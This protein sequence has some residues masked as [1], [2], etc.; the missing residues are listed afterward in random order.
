MTQDLVSTI[1][2]A[3]LLTLGGTWLDDPDGLARR[4]AAFVNEDAPAQAAHV[5]HGP[6]GVRTVLFTD[7]VGHTEMMRR[8]GDVRGRDVLREHERIVR[9]EIAK[10]DGTEI[11]S[12]GDGF[13]ISFGSVA[14]A[15]ECAVSIQRAAARRNEGADEPILLRMG[16][17]AGE[18]IEDAGDLFG[19]SVILAARIGAQA[20]SGEI[21]VPETVRH[22]LAGKGFTFA[23]RGTFVP[24]GF[25]DEVRLFEVRWRD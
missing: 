7:L 22:L 11:K 5:A 15:M 8:L 6:S 2:D 10:H 14:S 3:R 19:E 4:I 16:M 23:D 1:P 21:L 25:D 18:P 17:N 13:M 12:D 24:K 9:G 20:D